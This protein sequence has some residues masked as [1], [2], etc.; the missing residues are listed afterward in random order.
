M[1]ELTNYRTIDILDSLN[2]DIIISLKGFDVLRIL[3][4]FTSYNISEW[5]SDKTRFF[6]DSF[7]FFRIKKCW[8]KRDNSFIDWPCSLKLMFSL[9][10]DSLNKKKT[11]GIFLGGVSD[12]ETIMLSKHLGN[13]LGSSDIYSDLNCNTCSDLDSRSNYTFSS[14]DELKESDLC[15]I[16]GSDVRSECPTL[17]LLIKKQVM[18]GRLVVSYIGPSSDFSYPVNHIGLDIKSLISLFKKHPF[19]VNLNQSKNPYII[20]GESFNSSNLFKLVYKLVGLNSFKKFDLLFLLGV[21]DLKSYRLANPDSFIIYVGSHYSVYNLEMAD[22]ILPSSIFIEKDF[23]VINLEN[24]IKESKSLRKI[25]GD[26]RSE[27]FLL[28]VLISLFDNSL[29]L[30]Q[31]EKKKNY[32]FVISFRV[33]IYRK[34]KILN[35]QNLVLIRSVSLPYVKK[36]LVVR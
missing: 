18:E 16:I 7:N 24:I 32:G 17:N 21:N 10:N 22:L 8:L 29:N 14:F 28:L 11:L 20:L 27:S 36:F 25:S 2:S 13:M 12:L 19:S 31:L 4:C 15:L 3:P 34:K 6:Y 33:S 1:G 9:F 23:K 26:I 35:F 30:C 5:I